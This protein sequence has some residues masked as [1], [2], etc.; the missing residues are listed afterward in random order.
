MNERP[1]TIP[2]QEETVQRGSVVS[3]TAHAGPEA[4]AED[5]CNA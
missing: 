4:T 3:R 2:S 1:A 5:S